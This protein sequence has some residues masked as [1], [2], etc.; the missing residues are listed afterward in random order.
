MA[1]F[2]FKLE[3]VLKHRMAVED[4]CQREMAA[5]LRHRMIL[6]DQL[7]LMQQTIVESRRELA[8]GLTGRVDTDGIN[9]FARYSGQVRQRAQAIVARIAGVE[10]QIEAAR[11]KL[12]EA[13][14]ARKA[15]ELLRDRQ[16]QQWQSEE[17]RREAVV[18]DEMAVQAYGRKLAVGELE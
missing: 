14:T 10:K 12:L 7:R 8:R 6:L 17:D 2:R 11:L 18:L 16:Q 13:T 9:Q 3:P 4:Q 5:A 15:L 1:Q